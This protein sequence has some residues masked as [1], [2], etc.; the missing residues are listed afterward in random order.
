VK[1]IGAE[2]GELLHLAGIDT[3]TQLPGQDVAAL[4]AQV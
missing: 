3:F 2:Y 4:V 1:G